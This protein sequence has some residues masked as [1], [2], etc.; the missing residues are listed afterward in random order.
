VLN[1]QIAQMSIGWLRQVYW[2]KEGEARG[3]RERGKREGKRDGE[4][5]R[6]REMGKSGEYSSKI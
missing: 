1:S 2:V 6:E 3:E 4:R 5:E